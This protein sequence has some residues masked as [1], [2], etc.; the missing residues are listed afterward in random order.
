MI[1]EDVF[2][3]KLPSGVSTQKS[4]YCGICGVSLPGYYFII[5]Q[6]DFEQLEKIQILQ[7]S[8]HKNMLELPVIVC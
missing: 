7:K 6:E 4:H 8:S 2:S 3:A 5:F 1:L